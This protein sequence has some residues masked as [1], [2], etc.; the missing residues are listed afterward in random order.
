[1]PAVLMAYMSRALKYGCPGA[2]GPELV[3]VPNGMSGRAVPCCAKTCHV[4][5]C[6]A[7]PCRAMLCHAKPCCASCTVPCLAKPCSATLAGDTLTSPRPAARLGTGSQPGGSICAV[8]TALAE[9]WHCRKETW[10]LCLQAKERSMHKSLL[11]TLCGPLGNTT[12]CRYRFA[13]L[14]VK[15]FTVFIINTINRFVVLL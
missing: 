12:A 10:R 2:G 3:H 11:C 6:H 8:L 4:E 7:M 15:G 5:P 14:C 9:A 1:M 13:G